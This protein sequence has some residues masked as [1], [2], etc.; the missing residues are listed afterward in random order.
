MHQNRCSNALQSKRQLLVIHH[1]TKI[2]TC[3]VNHAAINRTVNHA[4]NHEIAAVNREINEK[5]S[6]D[7]KTTP[8]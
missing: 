7:E 5:Q 1:T 8:R 3:G 4:M 2:T 6:T